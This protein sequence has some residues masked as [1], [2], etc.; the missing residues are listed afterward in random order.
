MLNYISSFSKF[1]KF[2]KFSIFPISIS[3]F[4]NL[5]LAISLASSAF[6]VYNFS[7]SVKFSILF[8]KQK[9]KQKPHFFFII[10]WFWNLP[11]LVYLSIFWG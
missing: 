9:A 8:A 11:S 6:S 2:S 5:S 4:S 10:S 3:N 7:S 1:S